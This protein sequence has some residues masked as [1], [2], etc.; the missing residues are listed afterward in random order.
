MS[1]H[2]Q[3]FHLIVMKLDKWVEV[4]ECCTIFSHNRVMEGSES[5]LIWL[6]A[7]W[8]G[9]DRVKGSEAIG[10]FSITYESLGPSPGIT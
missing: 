9:S 1:V 6:H 5:Y 3:F 2:P 10:G 8:I 4:D 7:R